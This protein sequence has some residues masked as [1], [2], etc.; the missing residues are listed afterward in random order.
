MATNKNHKKARQ[1]TSEFKAKAVK[2]TYLRG[3]AL[4]L[5][6]V[7][8]PVGWVGLIIG[9]VAVAGVAAATSIGVNNIVKENSGSWYDSIMKAIGV[10]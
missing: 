6:V 1:Y 7:T 4:G 9:G 5:L 2:L 3:A 10:L 8:T